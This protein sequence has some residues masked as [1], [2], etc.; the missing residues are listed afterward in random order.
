MKQLKVYE[1]M[2]FSFTSTPRLFDF[3]IKVVEKIE[4]LCFRE[5]F[6]LSAR[7]MPSVG[8]FLGFTVFPEI[9]FKTID[10]NSKTKKKYEQ[11]TYFDKTKNEFQPDSS[12]FD[13]CFSAP[14][15]PP[16]LLSFVFS[17]SSA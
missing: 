15:I 16:S 7:S 10:K 6:S 14:G 4:Y 9:W 17:I 11:M 3:E 8:A 13:E 5:Q 2:V 1:H 12:N